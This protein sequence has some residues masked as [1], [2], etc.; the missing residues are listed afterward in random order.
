MSVRHILLKNNDLFCREKKTEEM[1][2]E[3]KEVAKQPETIENKENEVHNTVYV[4]FFS[5]T[6]RPQGRAV[7]A[8]YFG[9]RGHWFESR[10]RRDS[11]R[12]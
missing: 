10:W 3:D 2:P 4:L 12:T 1:E 9:S 11:S 6:K 5:C 8:P 7:S